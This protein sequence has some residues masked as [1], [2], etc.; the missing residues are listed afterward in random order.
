MSFALCEIDTAIQNLEQD[1]HRVASWCCENHFLINRGKTSMRGRPS[2]TTQFYPAPAKI[3]PAANQA[4]D[5]I[6]G[7]PRRLGEN[8][9]H[10]NRN[11]TADEKTTYRHIC[12]I[13]GKSLD[14]WILLKT[15]VLQ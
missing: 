11:K 12:F 9:I 5:K 14:L 2:V 7:L 10:D 6:E 13:F 4:P 1:L 8:K 3:L 15:Q